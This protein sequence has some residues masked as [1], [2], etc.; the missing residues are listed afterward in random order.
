[1]G[2]VRVTKHAIKRWRERVSPCTYAQAREAILAHSPAIMAAANFGA[3]TVKL[4]SN[5]R[6]KLCGSTVLTVLP[7]GR[8]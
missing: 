1:M 8:R 7:E 5:H 6:L 2:G 3:D 4:G